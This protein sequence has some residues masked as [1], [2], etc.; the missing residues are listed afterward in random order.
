M[1]GNYFRRVYALPL[2]ETAL[3]RAEEHS[4]QV[5]GQERREIE[6]RF[7][8]PDDPLNALICTPTMELGID[9]G[10][11]SAVTLRNVPPSPSHYAQRAGRAGRS[12]QPSLITVF[13]G[14]GFARGPHDQYFYRFPEKMIAGAI[15][16]PRFRLDNKALIRAHI[17]SLVL[18]T[19]GLRGVERLPGRPSDLLDLGQENFPVYA[20]WEAAYRAGVD[21]HFSDIA[22]AVEE[23]F[24]QE[25]DRFEWFDW[26]FVEQTVRG[27]TDDLDIAMERWRLEYERLDAEREEINRLLGHEG[28]DPALNR[29][30]IVVEGK[31]QAMRR[32][33]GEWYLYRYLGGE[34]FLPG[35]AFPPQATVL[36]FDDQEDELARDPAIA[37]KEYAPGN[38]VYY[39]GQRY[40]VTAYG[41]TP[42]PDEGAKPGQLRLGVDLEG[43]THPG[44]GTVL[45]T[46]PIS[47]RDDY[48][49]MAFKGDRAVMTTGRWITVYLE[50]QQDVATNPNAM[51]LDD[52]MVRQAK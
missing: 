26:Q 17:H 33:Q 32:G 43:G 29:R 21:R 35:Y 3:V 39:R 22:A 13:A 24:A 50:L 34:G 45:W 48:E 14:V 49:L 41:M 10:H 42:A 16:A 31:L 37:M 15:A 19:M 47:P 11:L 18:E 36:S 12:G 2:G 25:I 6:L 52:V 30:R 46:E 40:E 27:F 23:A 1:E 44:D 20:D 51:L 38:F 5:S 4:G 8:D 9:I 28:G 7:R